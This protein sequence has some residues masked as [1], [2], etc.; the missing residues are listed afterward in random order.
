MAAGRLAAEVIAGAV[1]QADVSA[2]A[3][4]AYSDLWQRGRGREMARNYR[5]R[6]RFPP[7]QRTAERFV[8]LF[9]LSIGATH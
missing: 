1:V 5:L 8:Q 2:R 6:A 3:L 4:S 9:A 7:E